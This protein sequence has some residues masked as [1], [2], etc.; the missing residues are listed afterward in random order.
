MLQLLQHILL[1]S[2]SS[3]L[4]RGTFRRPLL[5]SFPAGTLSWL[6][7][8]L[9]ARKL[10]TAEAASAYI[11]FSIFRTVRWPEQKHIAKAQ[12]ASIRCVENLLSVKLFAQG[13]RQ[14]RQGNLP[15]SHPEWQKGKIRK[16]HK[17]TAERHRETKQH[18]GREKEMERGKPPHKSNWPKQGCPP[19]SLSQVAGQM[20]WKISSYCTVITTLAK[21]GFSFCF[22]QRNLR[23]H[24]EVCY[25]F[26]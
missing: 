16:K 14:G 26:L 3:S 7:L 9:N 8:F 4:R 23:Q 25:T 2:S 15:P 11:I 1:S 10:L 13:Q 5:D 20:C 19:P 22:V 12:T 21:N 17:I 18:R 6:A 24:R